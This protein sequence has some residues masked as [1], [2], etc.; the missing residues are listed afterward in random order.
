MESEVGRPQVP[1]NLVGAAELRHGCAIAV[2]GPVGRR[3]RL[4]RQRAESQANRAG[5]VARLPALLVAS[6][7]GS[8]DPVGPLQR[9]VL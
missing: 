2:L 3:R 1:P 6:G 4:E 7:G 9:L 5:V 8:F